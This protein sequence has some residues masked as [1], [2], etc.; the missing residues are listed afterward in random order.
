[1]TTSI[2]HLAELLLCEI[3]TGLIPTTPAFSD[4][5]FI[6]GHR[7]LDKTRPTRH[8]TITGLHQGGSC[9]R[10]GIHEIQLIFV[11]MVDATNDGITTQSVFLGELRA[12]LSEPNIPTLRPL[13]NAST[14]GIGIS[15]YEPA[16]PDQ[17]GRDSAGKHGTALT[18]TFLAIH[19]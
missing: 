10:D 5:Q 12:I 2:E 11:P 19:T 13:L 16:A 9:I 15:G 3:L 17:E 8:C 14:L 18:Y 4:W 7:D 1:M 6:P